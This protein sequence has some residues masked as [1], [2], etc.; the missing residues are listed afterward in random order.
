MTNKLND[1]TDEQLAQELERRAAEKEQLSKV[2]E[3]LDDVDWSAVK[4]ICVS[5]IES[6]SKADYCNDNSDKDYIF[7]A[8][9]S[10]VYGPDI[11]E[12]RRKR[13]T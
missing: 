11:W 6:M 1:F 13:L 4:E 3:P 2:P 7:E 12:W 10:A 5:H 8:A 9:I